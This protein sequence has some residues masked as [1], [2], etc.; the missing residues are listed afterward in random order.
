MFG[1]PMHAVFPTL[2][3]DPGSLADLTT[4]LLKRIDEGNMMS[5][6]CERVLFSSQRGMLTLGIGKSKVGEWSLHFT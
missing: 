2:R 5:D 1:T 6:G 3:L 4:G